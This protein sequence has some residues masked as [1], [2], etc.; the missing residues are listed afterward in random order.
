MEETQSALGQLGAHT[1]ADVRSV[2]VRHD[3]ELRF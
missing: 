1:P 2:V 3:G